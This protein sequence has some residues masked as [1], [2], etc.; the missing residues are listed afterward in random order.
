LALPDRWDDPKGT[1]AVGYAP[2]VKNAAIVCFVVALF[3]ELYG[4]AQIAKA[5]RQARDALERG[6][7][8]NLDLDGVPYFNPDGDTGRTA[9][10]G[11]ASYRGLIAIVCG[12]LAGFAGNLLSTL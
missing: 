2:V 11:Q 9:L 5:A 6:P 4:V 10:L 8:M 7:F 12:V 3:A 1:G